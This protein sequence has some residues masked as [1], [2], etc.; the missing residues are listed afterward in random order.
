MPWGGVPMS[1]ERRRFLEDYRLNYYTVTE[2]AERFSISR[3]TA[4][5][6]IERFKRCGESGFQELSRRPPRSP[7]Q[8]GP[9]I[10]K[11]I[12][13]LRSA[14][15]RWGPAPPL[16]LLGRRH[17]RRHLPS[18]TTICRSVARHGLVRRGRGHRR[19]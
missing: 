7:C 1:E 4:H 16:Y 3:K 10:A 8:T 2:L 11:Q 6:W 17:P 5:K 14:H 18:A 9:A 13:E 19:A 12:I 15:P